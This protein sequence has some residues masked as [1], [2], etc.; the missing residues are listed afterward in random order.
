MMYELINRVAVLLGALLMVIVGRNRFYHLAQSRR[1]LMG[2]IASAFCNGHAGRVAQ[3]YAI[4]VENK[5]KA[6]ISNIALKYYSDDSLHGF[7]DIDYGKRADNKPLLQQQRGLIVPLV[8]KQIADL[9]PK[10]VLELGTGNGDILAHLAQEHPLIQFIGADL[11]VASA[12]KKHS[13]PNL[14]FIQGYA[15]DLLNQGEIAGDIVFGSSTFCVFAPL[16]LEAYLAAMP[17]TKGIA[18]SEPV[19]FG[20]AHTD[21]PKPESRH[22]DLYMWWHNYYA[23]LLKHEFKVDDYRTVP[24][25]YSHSPNCSVVLISGHRQIK[26]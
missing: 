23:Y 18:I 26:E 2:R 11:S 12:L 7:G 9:K 14:R 16:E 1:G 8:E 10:T 24:F 17:N 15:L 19:T 22:M 4:F 13:L 6:R 21:D 25:S 5:D 20:N 3:N